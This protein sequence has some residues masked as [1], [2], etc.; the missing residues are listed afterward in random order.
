MFAEVSLSFLAL[1]APP[2]ASPSVYNRGAR[3]YKSPAAASPCINTCG[4]RKA[5]RT[6]AYTRNMACK[7][8]GVRWVAG[9]RELPFNFAREFSRAAGDKQVVRRVGGHAHLDHLSYG[10]FWIICCDTGVTNAC[11]FG[12]Y[13]LLRR[14]DVPVAAVERN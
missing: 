8:L 13:A 12:T 5:K 9:W 7:V 14:I 3:R 1:C 4:M 6:F 2:K 10:P 11:N